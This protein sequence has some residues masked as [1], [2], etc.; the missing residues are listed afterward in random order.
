MTFDT[1]VWLH[2]SNEVV[3]MCK[4]Q[5]SKEAKRLPFLRL[6]FLLIYDCA[7]TLGW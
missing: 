5:Q 6:R 2:I 3:E 1:A 4:T 7:M